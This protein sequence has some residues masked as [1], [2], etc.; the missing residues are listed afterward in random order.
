MINEIKFE[1]WIGI[2]YVHLNKD[3]H[4]FYGDNLDNYYLNTINAKD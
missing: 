1:N 4:F 3:V 2:H